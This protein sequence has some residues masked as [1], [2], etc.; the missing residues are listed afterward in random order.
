MHNRD[1]AGAGWRWHND[2]Y[3]PGWGAAP[4]GKALHRGWRAPEEHH[5]QLPQVPGT[6]DGVHPQSGHLNCAGGPHRDARAAVQVRGNDAQL[7]AHRRGEGV[8]RGGGGG[9]RHEPGGCEPSQPHRHQ[10]RAGWRHARLL[11]RQGCRLQE[12]LLL[13]WLRAA[14]QVFP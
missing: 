7:E 10:A 12:D 3:H 9:R 5:P 13:R 6:G 4:A 8:L 14:A 11:P 1:A 2:R